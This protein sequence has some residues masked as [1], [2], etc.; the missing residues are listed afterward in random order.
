MILSIVSGTYNRLDHLKK[1]VGSARLSVG[2]FISYEIVLVDGGSTDGTIEWCKEQDDIVLIE[3]GELLGAIKAFNAGFRAARGRYV[4]AGNDDIRFMNE[5]L[6]EAVAYMESNLDVGIGCFDQDRAH[7]GRW[8]GW[9]YMPA[10]FDGRRVSVI[11]GQ[12]CIIPRWLGNEVGWWGNTEARTYGGDNEMSCQVLERGYRV[13]PIPCCCIEDLRIEDD[14]RKINTV[15]N[16]DGQ[17]WGRRW[18]RN[19]MTGPI[20]RHTPSLPNPIKPIPRCLYLPIY[21]RGHDIQR[22]QKHG[23][24]DA[25]ISAGYLL[26]EYD[27]MSEPK[28]VERMWEILDMFN[29]QFV[30]SQIHSPDE[31]TAQQIKELRNELPTFKWVNWNGDYHPEDLFSG[32]NIALARAF[33]L[34]L[35]VTT[36]VASIYDRGR[37]RWGYWQIGY[38]D[39]AAYPNNTTPRHDVVF[40]ANGYSR[41]R[42]NLA[43]FLRSMPYDVGL[44]GSWDSQF[45]PNGSN[46]YNFDEGAKL[47]RAAK[48][49]IGDDQ[50]GATGFVSNRL[51]QAMSAGGAMFLHKRVP[52]LEE[53]LGLR[54]GI[55]LVFWDNGDDLAQKIK[56]Y[57][58]NEDVRQRIAREGCSFVRTY[59]SFDSR[60]KQ[61]Q[62]MI[63]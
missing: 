50:W 62:E 1:M 57:L 48:L 12:V 15:G 43:R 41:S 45:K 49:S 54:D 26:Y 39:S 61:L 9:E 30:L 33:D 14:L 60:V 17:L 18:S 20:I 21:E 23:L 16:T 47:Y 29:P 38:E 22:T 5:T 35:V 34:Q 56:Y 4:V 44:Y 19:G 31:F 42:H 36:D 13:E 46:L 27:Y 63:N 6:V 28:P 32:P 25:L 59:H 3:Q 2:N 37:V 7:P 24:R 51:F 58:E 55:H 53:L 40:L 11:Y 8:G 52:G 10:V